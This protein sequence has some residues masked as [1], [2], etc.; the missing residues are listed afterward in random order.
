MASEP[1]DN[2]IEIECPECPDHHIEVGVQAMFE[3]ILEA[4]PQYNQHE[5]DVFALEW[6]EGA[7]NRYDQEMEA[8]HKDRAYE[9]GV[10][11]LR[12]KE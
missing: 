7:Y 5:A 8:Y 10:S 11:A 6:M 1:T 3:H 9:K 2:T 12:G 4:H